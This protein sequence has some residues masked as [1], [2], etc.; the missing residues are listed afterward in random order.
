MSQIL[1]NKKF[2]LTCIIT[3]V[4]LAVLIPIIL[5]ALVTPT[6]EFVIEQ[7]TFFP[8][9][10]LGGT[11]TVE[12]ENSLVMIIKSSPA[13]IPI[14]ISLENADGT[15]SWNK[16]IRGDQTIPVDGIHDRFLDLKIQNLSDTP[17][18]FQATIKN[19]PPAK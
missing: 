1:K 2:V 13:D 4:T 12:K 10:F 18:Q 17:V 6:N 15:F 3:G 19:I 11:I 16:E 5:G 14:Q 8:N 7:T 9:S